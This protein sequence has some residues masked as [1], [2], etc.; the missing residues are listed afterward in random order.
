MRFLCQTAHKLLAWIEKFRG[1]E[2]TFESFLKK[3][4]EIENAVKGLEKAM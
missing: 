3:N 4:N 1:F 2:S